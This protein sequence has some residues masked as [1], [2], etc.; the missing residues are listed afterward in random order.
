MSP[1]HPNTILITQFSTILNVLIV[2]KN[3]DIITKK[4]I[5]F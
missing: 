1:H 2:G 3:K 4:I 5:S